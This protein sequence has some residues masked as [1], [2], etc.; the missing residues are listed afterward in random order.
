MRSLATYEPGLEDDDGFHGSLHSGRLLKGT[1]LK[2]NDTVHW[3]DR[4]GVTP[5]SLLL[6]IASNEVLQS[7]K[8]G[9][10]K[11]IADKPLPDPAQLNCTIPIAEWE[12][13]VDNTP[14]PPWAHVVIVY[15]VNLATAEFFTYAPAT[16]GAHIAYDAPPTF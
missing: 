7:W 10:A 6:V 9:K 12:R 4:D 16:T 8:D 5:P 11:V 13:G 2:W 15:F 1:S 14:R 3:A